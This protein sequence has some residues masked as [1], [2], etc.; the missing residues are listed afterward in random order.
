[1][2]RYTLESP[3]IRFVDMAQGVGNIG[4]AF[5]RSFV[6]TIDPANARLRL[7]GPADGRLVV[8]EEHKPRYGVQLE[9]LSGNPLRVL[10]VDAGSPAEAAGLRAGD[11]IVRMNGRPIEDLGIDE[12]LEALK[13]S[14][15]QVAVERGKAALEVTMALR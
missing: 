4:G 3:T 6:L 8:N 13:T 14:P 1:M 9:D 10:V 2:G 7:A 5:L 12:R 11:V 15:L